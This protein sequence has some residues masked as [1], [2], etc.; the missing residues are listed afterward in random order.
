MI[1]QHFKISIRFSNNLIGAK[2][3]FLEIGN[4]GWLL[5]RA[6]IADEKAVRIPTDKILQLRLRKCASDEGGFFLR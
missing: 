1:A 3:F 4:N 2:C 6:S 5:N